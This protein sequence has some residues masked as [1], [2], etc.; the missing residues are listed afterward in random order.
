MQSFL[1]AL[2]KNYFLDLYVCFVGLGAC[3]E[4]RELNRN[5]FSPT[6]WGPGVELGSSDLL[7]SAFPCLVISQLLTMGVI[8]PSALMSC[9]IGFSSIMDYT[10]EL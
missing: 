4:V 1:P 9:H 6:M 2:F 3:V 5:R 7:A 8:E 10:P